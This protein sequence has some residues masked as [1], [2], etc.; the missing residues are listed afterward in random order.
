MGHDD[1][2]FHNRRGCEGYEWGLE[3][4]QLAEL[5]D[6]RS[7]LLGVCFLPVGAFGAR[8]RVF[9][10]V[11]DRPTGPYTLVG[12]A[13]DP[14]AYGRPGENG[15]GAVVVHDGRVYLYFQHRDG[16]GLPWDVHVTSADAAAIPAAAGESFAAA[17]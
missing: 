10:A 15:H 12:P 14:V 2:P 3:G 7:L 6:G 4:G 9:V 16:D 1:V 8:Q 13:I 5:P 11:A 17:S